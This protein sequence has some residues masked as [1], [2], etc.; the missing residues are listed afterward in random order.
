M[1]VGANSLSALAFVVANFAVAP[2]QTVL[3]IPDSSTDTVGTY[4]SFDGSFLGDLIVDS[5]PGPAGNLE[6]PINAVV[7]PDAL[8][9]VSDQ[10]KDAVLRYDQSGAF[11]DVFCDATDGLNNVRGIQFFGDDLLVCY[12]STIVPTDRGVAR[13]SP[14]GTRL[15]NFIGGEVDPFDI[16]VFGTDALISDIATNTVIRFNLQGTL[17]APL[18]SIEFPEQSTIRPS[19]GRFLNIAHTG[20]RITEFELNG[21]ITAT[22]PITLLGRGVV[23][24]EN[25]NLLSTN[26]SNVREL[27]PLTGATVRVIRNGSGFRFVER[28][29]LGIFPCPQPGCEGGDATGDCIVDLNDLTILLS[30]FGESGAPGSVVGDAN[31]D[32]RVDLAD[33]TLLLSQFGSNC[34]P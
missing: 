32:G 7:G 1:G 34:V 18:F 20:N 31:R 8:I 16:L 27:D 19:T 26:A 28:V 12:A 17:V 9:Y 4:S 15:P 10:L 24:L 22:I 3:L 33:L 30:A 2:A 21:S 29:I 14:S 6:T 25:G 23:E 13:F 11:V 5:D